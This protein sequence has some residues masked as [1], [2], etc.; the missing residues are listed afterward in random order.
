VHWLGA[1]K[2]SIIVIQ[3][4]IGYY[5]KFVESLTGFFTETAERQE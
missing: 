3:A 1:E 4:L 2:Y 5:P